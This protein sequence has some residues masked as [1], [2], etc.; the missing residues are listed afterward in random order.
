MNTKLI[1][2]G[3]FISGI[4]ILY[5]LSTAQSGAGPHGGELKE[6][7]NY[8]I[9]MKATFPNLYFYLLTQKLEP[10]NNKGISCE[11]TFFFPDQTSVVL[12][13]KP[14]EDDGFIIESSKIV[15]NSCRVTFNVFGKSV[16]ALF[17]KESMIVTK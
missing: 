2:F 5:S 14:F 16:S 4:I 12:S 8:Y 6:T 9:E 13:L 10:V 1:L 11:A 7:E 17:E 15:Y 3:S